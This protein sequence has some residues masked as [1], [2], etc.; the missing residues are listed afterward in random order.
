MTD[1]HF[2]PAKDHDSPHLAIDERYSGMGLLIDL[3]YVS[4]ER[5]AACEKYNVKFVERLKDNWKASGNLVWS[6][7]KQGDLFYS[8]QGIIVLNGLNTSK[9]HV[10]NQNGVLSPVE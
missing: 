1:F 5:I 7:G 4:I 6:L 8:I 3:G 9:L 10:E 2:S